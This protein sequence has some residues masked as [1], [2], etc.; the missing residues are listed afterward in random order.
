[1]G[2]DGQVTFGEIT[3][4][5]GARKVRTMYHGKILAG[6]A[7]SAAD[8]FTLFGKFEGHLEANEGNLA[9]AAVELAKE[10]A[11]QTG[12]ALD[13]ERSSALEAFIQLRVGEGASASQWAERYTRTRTE[14]ERLSY[15]REFE[16][17]VYV[18]VLLAQDRG[19]DALAL[20]AQ[21]LPIVEAAQSRGNA[22]ELYLLQV[23]AF[24]S[25]GQLDLA[26]RLL[27]RCLAL[28]E[29]EDHVRLFVDEGEPM[30]RAIGDVVSRLSKHPTTETDVNVVTFANRLL[31]TFAGT[32]APGD[33][34]DTT[35]PP[36]TPLALR[37][38]LID[39]LTEREL[40]VLY[41]VTAGLSNAA[42]AEQLII[43]VGTVKTHLK[44]I[45]RKLAV[46]SRTQAVA[47]AR[48]LG[49]LRN[50]QPPS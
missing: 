18:R 44:H 27:M 49:L 26:S 24:R 28:A 17:L 39:P 29:P 3:M 13:I 30:Q 41:L 8:A 12:I 40:E 45:Y 23:L 33:E 5:A 14:A 32:E 7:G 15:L 22:L 19:A 38:N 9:R 37:A 34:I 50:D 10:T 2:G 4:K 6:F 48:M 36:S 43:S 47:Q 46:Q 11:K 21:W 42:I 31:D 35:G 1:L 25:T 16:T 20:L